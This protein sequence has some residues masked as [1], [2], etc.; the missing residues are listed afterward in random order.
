MTPLDETTLLAYVDG[1]LAPDEI[2]RVEAALQ[3]DAA[4]REIVRRLRATP[5][6]LRS[7]FDRALDRPLPPTLAEAILRHPTGRR[8][9]P[10][11]RLT[12]AIAAGVLLFGMGLGAGTWLDGARRTATVEPWVAAV[13]NYQA[14]YGRAT[15]TATDV[16]GVALHELARRLSAGF[17]RVVT[18]PD[19]RAHGL[20]FT[21]GQLLE[22]G[23]QPL[24]QLVYLPAQGNP[25]ALCQLKTAQT[26]LAPT[27]G[28]ANGMRYVQWRTNGVAYLLIGDTSASEMEKLAAAAR[29]S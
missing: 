7:V 16:N 27:A 17:G 25:I 15:V 11:I 26:D 18:I 29:A 8:V 13:A 22:F 24:V 9:L 4:A 23:G 20:A 2:Q 14:L 28:I 12:H 19:L 10:R 5:D 1:Q 6:N 21:R 3:T